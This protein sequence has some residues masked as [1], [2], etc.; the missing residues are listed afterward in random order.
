MCGVVY[1]GEKWC[2]GWSGG[3]SRVV[4]WGSGGVIGVVYWGE[5]WCIGWSGVLGGVV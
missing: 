5:K 2:I 3:V 1:W 4:Y